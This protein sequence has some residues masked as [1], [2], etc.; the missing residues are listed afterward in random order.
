MLE[1]KVLE[2]TRRLDEI[3]LPY[4]ITG[5]VAAMLYGEP[6]F[7]NDLDLVLELKKADVDKLIQG[8]PADAFYLPPEEVLI[9]EQKRR[10]RGHFNIIHHDS[11]YKADVYLAGEDPLHRWAMAKRRQ[12]DF[13]GGDVWL[14]PPEYVIVRKLQFFKEG[15]SEKHI[16]DI[17]AMMESL[18]DQLDRNLVR[19]KAQDLGVVEEWEMAS[20]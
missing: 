11:M 7:T 9:I 15:K 19:E 8:F 10:I 5:S 14:A 2:F 3:Q 18:E 17:Q 4:M 16:R 12:S 6:R 13:A 20:A 1:T